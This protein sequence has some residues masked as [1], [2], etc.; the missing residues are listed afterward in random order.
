M[1]MSLRWTVL[2]A[3]GYLW[4]ADD[5]K[6]LEAYLGSTPKLDGILSPGEYADATEFGGVDGWKPQFAPVTD[7]KDLSVRAWVKHDDKRLYFAFDV[8]DDV[9]YGIDT[10]RWLPKNNP[11]AH[12]LT[13]EG[14]PWFGDEIEVLINGTKRWSG[15]EDAAG[16]GE[17]WQM[18]CNLTKSRK[19]GIG[20]GGL[21][22]GEPRRFQG[23]WDR[24]GKWI[25]SDAQE[26]VAKQRPGGYV[27]EWAINFNPCLEIWPGIFYNP[28]LGEKKMGLNILIGDLD[29]D[30]F[31]SDNPYGFHHENSWSGSK[32]TRTHLREFG[33]LIVKPGKKP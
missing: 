23:A 28:A 19:G 16:N 33:T 17:S 31:G 12:E 24:Y 15:E 6:T 4:A 22:E 26:C 32:D 3:A 7:P 9:L 18:V 27:I 2:L 8:T 1:A 21:L 25:A 20:V 11:K 13:R 5:P 29:R 30:E 14:F 10:P